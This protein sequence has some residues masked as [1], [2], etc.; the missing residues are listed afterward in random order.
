MGTASNDVS[1][2]KRRMKGAEEMGPAAMAAG[3]GGQ[4]GAATAPVVD[5]GGNGR[6]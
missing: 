1:M 2:T 6:R 3:D 5:K 4:R